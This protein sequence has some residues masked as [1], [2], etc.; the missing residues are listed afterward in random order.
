MPG[1]AVFRSQTLSR[2]SKPLKNNSIRWSPIQVLHN[3]P[4]FLQ[5]QTS[6]LFSH[7]TISTW[8]KEGG[9]TPTD[10]QIS[11]EFTHYSVELNNSINIRYENSDIRLK[12]I[13]RFK[14]WIRFLIN[15]TQKSNIRYQV[16]KK[17]DTFLNYSDLN[18]IDEIFG[19]GFL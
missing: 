13:I 8:L 1:R 12:R 7:W 19:F 9:W 10:N 4:I 3:T 16:D 11:S 6:Q 18:I 17:P 14:S 15:R 5:I 2:Q